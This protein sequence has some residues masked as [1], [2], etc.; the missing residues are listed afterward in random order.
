[1]TEYSYSLRVR[2]PVGPLKVCPRVG[3]TMEE[4]PVC[5]FWDQLVGEAIAFIE[6]D[7]AWMFGGSTLWWFLFGSRPP[8]DFLWAS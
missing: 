2:L 5:F 1:M 6:F 8:L 4:A 3:E 7:W